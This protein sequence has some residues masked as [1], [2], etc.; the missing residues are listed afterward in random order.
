VIIPNPGLLIKIPHSLRDFL[1][2]IE[3][4]EGLLLNG[5]SNCTDYQSVV[6]F[7]PGTLPTI[8]M[9]SLIFE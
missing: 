8:L 7:V 4:I 3:S 5:V 2:I 6:A 1:V 9:F